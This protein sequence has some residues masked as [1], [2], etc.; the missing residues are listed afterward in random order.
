MTGHN[1]SIVKLISI[2]SMIYIDCKDEM[3]Y[4]SVCEQPGE[5][6]REKVGP[7]SKKISDVLVCQERIFA[8]CEDGWYACG[9]NKYGELRLGNSSK[10]ED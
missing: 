7:P 4:S 3:W 8:N 10:W 5:L 1:K 6:Y 2:D 9:K